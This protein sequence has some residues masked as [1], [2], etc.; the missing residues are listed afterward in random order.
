[1]FRS[2]AAIEIIFSGIGIGLM[3]KKREKTEPMALTRAIKILRRIFATRLLVSDFA[4]RL[5]RRIEI[6]ALNKT[7]ETK[8]ETRRASDSISISPMLNQLL[9]RV[10]YLSACHP[11]G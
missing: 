9:Q 7:I 8:I 11:R 2:R 6:G 1:M 3:M 4:T 10:P 5:E